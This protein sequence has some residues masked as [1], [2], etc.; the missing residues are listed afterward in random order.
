MDPELPKLR[1]FKE[2]IADAVKK[3]N[4]SV[5][6]MAE[7]KRRDRSAEFQEATSLR[8]P[9][10]LRYILMSLALL[11]IILLVGGYFFFFY[12]AIPAV[13]APNIVAS[14]II[15]S[16]E[17]NTINIGGLTSTAIFNAISNEKRGQLPLGTIEKV[18]FTVPN[19]TSTTAANTQQFITALDTQIPFGL[20]RALD[21]QFF[22]GF[23]SYSDNE[24]LLILTTNDYGS[25]YAGMLQ[26][27]PDMAD[28]ISGLFTTPLG[29]SNTSTSSISTAT[30]TYSFEDKVIDNKDTRALIDPSGNIVFFYSFV[31]PS[32]IVFTTNTATFQEI[33]NRLAKSKL[34]H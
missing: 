25:A 17:N 32:T 30:S 28:N 20:L 13:N 26:W 34:I 14:D 16:D 8:S 23:H 33:L 12:K 21:P 3:D 7:S 22:F 1:T 15:S 5:V 31:D 27:E 24:P 6:K 4:V 19:G 2:D 11:I 29:I 9:K 18:T 10:N